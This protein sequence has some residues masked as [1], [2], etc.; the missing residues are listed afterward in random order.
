[1]KST[2]KQELRQL[3]VEELRELATSKREQLLRGRVSQATEGKGL[4]VKA[5]IIRR[6]I[7]RLETLITE[8][9]K[10]ASQA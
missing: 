7:A 9:T 1:M 10:K 4:G 6:D 5:R 3:S 8:K 2:E